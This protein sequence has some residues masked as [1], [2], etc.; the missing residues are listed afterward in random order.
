MDGVYDRNRNSDEQQQLALGGRNTRRIKLPVTSGAE[1]L[2]KSSLM[3]RFF[4]K[5]NISDVNYYWHSNVQGRIRDCAHVDAYVN[6][7]LDDNDNLTGM[8]EIVGV[9]SEVAMPKTEDIIEKFRVTANFNNNVLHGN[10]VVEEDDDDD[11]VRDLYQSLYYNGRLVA[12][13]YIGEDHILL[14]TSPYVE[15]FTSSNTSADFEKD[16]KDADYSVANIIRT[17]PHLSPQ[18]SDWGS[19]LLTSNILCDQ[20]Y[21]VR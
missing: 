2:D 13:L 4:P 15:Q 8:S 11:D 5:V 14:K 10:F 17:Y 6:V 7:T 19:K 21:K 20:V 12:L 18:N 9:M 3:Q 1:L 16:I